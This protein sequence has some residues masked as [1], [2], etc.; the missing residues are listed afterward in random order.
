MKK[1]KKS[2]TKLQNLVKNSAFF[3]SVIENNDKFKKI[4]LIRPKNFVKPRS[5]LNP[6]K[7]L[8]YLKKIRSNKMLNTKDWRKDL[9]NIKSEV[10]LLH[11]M[12]KNK[13]EK[14]ICMN[15]SINSLLENKH[16]LKKSLL[17]KNKFNS[18][19]N[20]EI[21]LKKN[22]S[23]PVLFKLKNK[24]QFLSRK[25]LRNLGFEVQ[26]PRKKIIFNKSLNKSKNKENYSMNKLFIIK[27]KN[28]NSQ[29][30]KKKFNH[31]SGFEYFENKSKNY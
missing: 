24:N 30:K 14:H 21:P 5:S 6:I 19:Q 26:N 1:T 29:V 13:N 7:S 16:K 20:N 10:N 12:T 22:I 11:K 17:D 27:N 31:V 25:H 4:Y 15:L 3:K 2:E 8:D 18:L 23:S 28:S 9:K